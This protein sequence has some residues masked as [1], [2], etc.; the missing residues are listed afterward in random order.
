MRVLHNNL[1]LP[2]LL[3]RLSHLCLFLDHII[4]GDEDRVEGGGVGERAERRV[5]L[6]VEVDLA[7]VLRLVDHRFQ[8]TG[9]IGH[10]FMIRD[11]QVVDH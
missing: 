6:A 2:R 3:H 1:V 7:V 8:L 5:D 4:T 11:V 9:L 10:L